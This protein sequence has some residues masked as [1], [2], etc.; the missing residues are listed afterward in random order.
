MYNLIVTYPL[1]AILLTLISTLF[2]KYL[3]ERYFSQASRVTHKEFNDR[4]AFLEKECELRRSSCVQQRVTNKTYFEELIKAQAGCLDDVIEGEG[5]EAARRSQT[6]KILFCIMMT[7]LSICNALNDSALL[8]PKR[9]DCSDIS[10][11]M[12]QMG[13]I[14]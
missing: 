4:M 12:S 11:M 8:G 3:W 1:S 2:G 9:I 10:K 6:G 14:E 5:I 7:Q 13:V